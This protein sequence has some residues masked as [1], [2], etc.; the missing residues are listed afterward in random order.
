VTYLNGGEGPPEVVHAP[1][2]RWANRRSTHR[3]VACP[4]PTGK[5]MWALRRG[6]NVAV[7]PAHDHEAV[8]QTTSS[9]G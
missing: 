2:I 3:I 7:P 6:A 4:K 5:P 8:Y 9:T 1:A